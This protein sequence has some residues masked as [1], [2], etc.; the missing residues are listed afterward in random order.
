[1]LGNGHWKTNERQETGQL[2]GLVLMTFKIK[3]L[4]PVR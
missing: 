2:A 3:I 4:P 1:M